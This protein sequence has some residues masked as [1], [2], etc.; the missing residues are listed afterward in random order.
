MKKLSTLIILLTFSAAFGQRTYDQYSLEAS[1]GVSHGMNPS[2]T[3]LGHIDA[4]FR[5]MFDEYWGAKAEYG[6]DSFRTDAEPKEG[7]NYHRFSLQ[8]VYNLGRTLD[9]P[10]MTG[11]Y[12]NLLVHAGLGYSALESTTKLGIDNIGHV[13]AGL[14]PQ[15]WISD[16]FAIH[17]DISYIVNFTQNYQFDGTYLSSST[18]RET[19]SFVGGIVNGSVGLTFYFGKNENDSDWR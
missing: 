1:Y 10:Y 3:S 16:Q 15:F 13:I 7:T 6:Y 9:I 11:D 2:M 5:Y 19:A 18:R 17:A 12:V 14:T 8:G 4:G